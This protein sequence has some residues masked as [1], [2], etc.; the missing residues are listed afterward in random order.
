M[1]QEKRHIHVHSMNLGIMFIGFML[2][3]LLELQLQNGNRL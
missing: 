3:I 1:L 2:S